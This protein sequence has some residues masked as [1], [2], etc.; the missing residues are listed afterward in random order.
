M[1]ACIRKII[2]RGKRRKPVPP[3]KT[4]EWKKYG[5]LPP[6]KKSMGLVDCDVHTYDTVTHNVRRKKQGIS[7]KQTGKENK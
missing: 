6:S 4:H 2:Q 7:Y 3:P 5:K 1:L